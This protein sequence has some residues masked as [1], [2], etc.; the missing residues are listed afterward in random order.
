MWEKGAPT[1][2]N[3]SFCCVRAS[4]RRRHNSR[5]LRRR[6]ARTI[7]RQTLPERAW[8]FFIRKGKKGGEARRA[9][10]GDRT[11]PALGVC[12]APGTVHNK[13]KR[14]EKGI[15][16]GPS[17]RG[18]PTLRLALPPRTGRA[19]G[20]AKPPPGA[21][22]AAKQHWRAKAKEKGPRRG[23][24]R[25]LAPGFYII[26]HWT[27]TSQAPISRPRRPPQRANQ[28]PAR[29]QARSCRGAKPAQT[30]ARADS[31]NLRQHRAR[32]SPAAEEAAPRNQIAE[33]GPQGVERR[34][35][36]ARAE[37]RKGDPPQGS[38]QTGGDRAADRKRR[39]RAQARPPPGPQA[40]ARGGRRGKKN[41]MRGAE[42]SPPPAVTRGACPTGRADEEPTGA[43]PP[44]NR[45]PARSK[46]RF[47]AGGLGAVAEQGP[48]GDQRRPVPRKGRRWAGRGTKASGG[49]GAYRRMR[50]SAGAVV[51]R[52]RR[53]GGS[54]P[55][56]GD[57]PR[58]RQGRGAP[59]PKSPFVRPLEGTP[60]KAA[61]GTASL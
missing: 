27:Y 57:L 4:L 28:T 35:E 58:A 10:P 46:Y 61:R 31:S 52:A 2:Q 13:I 44:K 30:G 50:R 55:R 59:E 22:S 26:T 24:A 39:R 25:S 9:A 14:S 42:E 38:P 21:R 7:E 40:G 23:P 20:R 6:V 15:I 33:G 11:A 17:K 12:H 1:Q 51:P 45:P 43:R 49:P 47:K 34:R 53:G 29:P 37:T 36:K 16:S 41:S 18:R 5:F 3:F 19:G 54:T 8:R 60:S 48:R 56:A 32:A